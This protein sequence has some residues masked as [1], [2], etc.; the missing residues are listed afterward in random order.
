M[1]QKCR[2]RHFLGLFRAL[3]CKIWVLEFFVKYKIVPFDE[4]KLFVDKIKILKIIFREIFTK[5]TFFHS[6]FTFF[7]YFESKF[8]SRHSR[9]FHSS[10]CIRSAI[11]W[12]LISIE[13][14][15]I[16]RSIFLSEFYGFLV[17][18]RFFP[19]KNWI[20]FNIVDII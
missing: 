17:R 18:G 11:L 4:I 15:F 20:K 5:N 13:T 9:F 1:P 2:K 10:F 14:K 16:V 19:E 3:C 6:F 8:L 7:A 12:S